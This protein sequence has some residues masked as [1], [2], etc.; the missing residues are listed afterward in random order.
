MRKRKQVAAD[1]EEV[2]R[3]MEETQC[4]VEFQKLQ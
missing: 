4:K 3:A 1:I 2:E